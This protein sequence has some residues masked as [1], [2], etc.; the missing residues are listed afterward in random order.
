MRG[1]NP[2]PCLDPEQQKGRNACQVAGAGN[3]IVDSLCRAGF[4][5]TATVITWEKPSGD[6]AERVVAD[7][8]EADPCHWGAWQGLRCGDCEG[9]QQQA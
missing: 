8:R 5:G 3:S 1:A 6:K 9:H 2:F 4:I 7:A